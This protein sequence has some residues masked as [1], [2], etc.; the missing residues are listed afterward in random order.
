MVI[1]LRCYK[2]DFLDIVSL[3]N[4]KEWECPNCEREMEDMNKED[5]TYDRGCLDLN[6]MAP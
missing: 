5:E 3:A 1:H 6:I 2:C 4:A